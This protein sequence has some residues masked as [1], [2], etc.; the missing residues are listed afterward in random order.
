MVMAED[1]RTVAEIVTSDPKKAGLG[2]A[3]RV[4]L[5]ESAITVSVNESELAAN[6]PLGTKVAV[7]VCVPDV[8]SANGKVSEEELVPEGIRA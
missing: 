1:P 6:G 7:T 4:V 8:R 3:E 5:L 2:I